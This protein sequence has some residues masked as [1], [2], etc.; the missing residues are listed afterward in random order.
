MDTATSS[1][2][3]TSSTG[4]LGIPSGVVV[5]ALSGELDVLTVPEARQRLIDGTPRIEPRVVIDLK[6]VPFCDSSGV[7]LLVGQYKRVRAREGVMALACPTGRVRAVLQV[8]GLMRSQ[9]F[10]VY[11]TVEEA[12]AAVA[13]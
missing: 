11:D 9:M 12:R 3:S 8:T 1:G 6:G 7:G 13:T 2:T 4:T 10:D 5:I